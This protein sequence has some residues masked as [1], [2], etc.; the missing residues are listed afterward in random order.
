VNGAS[1]LIDLISDFNLQTLGNYLENDEAEPQ[2][3]VQVAPFG[4]TVSAL[5]NPNGREQ[6]SVALVWTSP[7]SVIPLFGEALQFR[8]VK[9]DQVLAEVRQFAEYILASKKRFRSVLVC[10]WTLP[11]WFRGHGL[12]DL[13]KPFGARNLL[14]KMNLEL[15]SVLQDEAGVYILDPRDWMQSAGKNAYSPKQW[16]LSKMPYGAEVL[17]RA[18]QEIKSAMRSIAGQARKLIV[19]DL[20]DTLWGGVVG[21]A[22]WE[23]L[24]LGGH[25]HVGEAYVDFQRTLKA[26]R[27][28]GILLAI[29]SKNEESVALQALRMHPEM[30]LRPQDFAGWRINW[31]DKARNIV[32]L[33]TELNL[34]LQ[35]VVFIDDNPAER[36]RVREALPEVLVPEWPADKTLFAITLSQMDCFDAPQLTNEDFSRAEMYDA[37]RGRDALKREVPRVEDW[38]ASLRTK[39]IVEELNGSNRARVAQLFNKTNQM[40]LST[41]RLTESELVQWAA[42]KSRKLFAFRV[43]DRFGDSGLT[44]IVTLDLNG[45]TAS[46]V[47]FILSCRVMGRKVEETMLAVAIEYCRGQQA[48]RL[49]AEYLPTAKNKPCHDFWIKTG[50]E[51]DDAQRMFW[52]DLAQ[53]YLAPASVAVEFA[54]EAGSAGP[55]RGLGVECVAE[56]GT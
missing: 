17:K 56:A 36:S 9:E 40:N 19:V 3:S 48:G 33:A 13:Q 37:E 24:R 47:D 50:F 16:Y 30:V 25:D 55:E 42:E 21:D 29:A 44:G 7:A 6:G 38:L 23:N 39:V 5:L 32:E 20:D 41:R 45:G 46:M 28:R 14:L 35:S 27:N 15:V 22:G 34:G 52:W 18:A 1:I 2:V 10:A 43:S 8:P 12:L 54:L 49:V 26:L 31:N 11:D 4:Q 53:S 51:H